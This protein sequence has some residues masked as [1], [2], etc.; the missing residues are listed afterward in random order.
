MEMNHENGLCEVGS[1]YEARFS[2]RRSWYEVT[3]RR[4]RLVKRGNL[5]HIYTHT[6]AGLINLG[7]IVVVLWFMLP[8]LN[9]LVANGIPEAP[10]E[11]HRNFIACDL[12]F[13]CSRV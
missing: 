2:L 4:R 7:G 3:K 13:I 9:K 5:T 12:T 1:R 8:D 11:F 6:I 10:E